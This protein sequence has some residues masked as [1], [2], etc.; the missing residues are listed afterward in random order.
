LQPVICFLAIA[1]GLMTFVVAPNLVV[2]HEV[3]SAT[4]MGLSW[5]MLGGFGARPPS[6]VAW[7]PS[8]L[9]AAVAV[10]IRETALPFVL[11]MG[12]F[13]V[14]H[15]QWR[16][17]AGW[18][19]VVVLLAACLALHASHVDAVT[20]SS[21]LT[22]VG[23]TNLAGWP[24]FVM[25]MHGATGLR[26]LPEWGGVIAVPLTMLG[27]AAWRTETGA[28]GFLLF[29]G[30]ALIFMA[31]GRPDNWYWGLLISPLFLLG[32]T[33]APQAIADLVAVIRGTARTN[34]VR[35]PATGR[36][37]PTTSARPAAAR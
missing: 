21:D 3:W 35:A 20:T 29:A 1:M 22:S 30:Y 15:R 7:L 10:L 27:W 6:L 25:A 36:Q 18:A 37:W 4:L 16:Q 5:G 28:F 24:F 34:G 23:W 14:W 32:L 17:V 26:V 2:S 12:A 13:A 33:F 8:V 9:L 19:A 31:L 11:L